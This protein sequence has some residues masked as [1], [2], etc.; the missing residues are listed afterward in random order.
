MIIRG[1]TLWQPWAWA[2]AH[3]GKN[4]ENRSWAPPAYMLGN[5]LAIHAGKTVDRDAMLDIRR[6]FLACREMPDEAL[7]HSAIVAVATLTDYV[8]P[9]TVY[10]SASP[11]FCGPYGWRLW[12]VRAIEPVSCRGAQGLWRLPP[13]VEETVMARYREVVAP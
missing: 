1:L 12:D 6:R 13:D 10:T 8:G 4:V 2:I 7:L 11:W 9:D 5:L 3:A